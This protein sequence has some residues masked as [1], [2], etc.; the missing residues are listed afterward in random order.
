MFN[1][2]GNTSNT[3]YCD[4]FQPLLDEL[5]PILFP[6]VLEYSLV[7]AAAMIAMYE[8]L[9]F[10]LT[11]SIM[12]VL[13]NA[14][15][16]SHHIH[17]IRLQQYHARDPGGA[18]GVHEEESLSKSHTGMYFGFVVLAGTIVS[19]ILSMYW[20]GQGKDW[21]ADLTFLITDII[22]SLLLLG[23]TCTAMASFRHL[24]YASSR[25]NKIDAILLFSSFAG[26]FL[27][28]VYTFVASVQ[29]INANGITTYTLLDT[30][31]AVIIVVQGS[32]QVIFIIDSMHRYVVFRRHMVEKPGREFV[33]FLIVVN[34]ATWIFKTIQEKQLAVSDEAGFFGNV[35]WSIILNLCLPL[36]LFFR[37][38]SSI[39]LA[40]IWHSAYIREEDPFSP[41]DLAEDIVKDLH[42]RL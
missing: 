10:Y 31:C 2:G 12:E 28:E 30:I 42:A 18:D 14:V 1:S 27:L 23:A 29:S 16:R 24:G 3:S 15:K 38:H 26:L 8:C 21:D 39:C 41:E 33:T 5:S 13:T 25:D 4:D 7:G 37:F 6:F 9:D 20:S 40:H 17:Q 35:A 34:V 32:L 36:L 19:I 11:K 22:I